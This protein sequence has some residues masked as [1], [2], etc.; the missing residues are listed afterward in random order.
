M[1]W[2]YTP[3]ILPMLVAAFI[4]AVLALYAYRRRAVSGATAFIILSAALSLWSLG[5]ALEIGA[6]TLAAKVFWAKVQYIGIVIVTPAWL[7]FSLQYTGRS[8]WLTRRNLLFL[9][10]I[11]SITLSLAW[12]TETHG[13]IWPAYSLATEGPFL[14]LEVSHIFGF[15]FI[16]LTLT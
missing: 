13:L 3:Y 15:G 14:A 9:A 2:R 4:S 5:Y 8:E 7:A 6:A 1:S 10:I 12:T 11:P 16:P